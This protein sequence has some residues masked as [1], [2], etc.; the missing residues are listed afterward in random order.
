MPF[1][2]REQAEHGVHQEVLV[3]HREH[4][5]EH[6]EHQEL[7]EQVHPEYCWA[8]IVV[9]PL[10]YMCNTLTCAKQIKTARTVNPTSDLWTTKNPTD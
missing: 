9:I 2:F 5:S 8:R 3:E 1:K 4:F 7:R 6:R 10:P